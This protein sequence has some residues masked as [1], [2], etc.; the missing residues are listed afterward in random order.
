M[1]PHPPRQPRNE[2]APTLAAST[3]PD[4]SP[5][6]TTAEEER[7]DG[8]GGL[9]EFPL[10]ERHHQIIAAFMAERQREASRSSSRLPGARALRRL[11]GRLRSWWAQP[12]AS[13]SA[14]PQE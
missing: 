12:K 4:H 3:A 7:A 5:T 8:D 10:Q 14:P 2:D 1:D 6:E 11:V 9:L 13:P